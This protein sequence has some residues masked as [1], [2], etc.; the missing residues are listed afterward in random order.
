MLFLWTGIIVA[1][2]NRKSENKLEKE[3]VVFL[4][5]SC[6]ASSLS[7]YCHNPIVVSG[8]VSGFHISVHRIFISISSMSAYVPVHINILSSSVMSP[9]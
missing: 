7:G 6:G 4:T 2:M 8:L 1:I 5:Q 3:I 9:C